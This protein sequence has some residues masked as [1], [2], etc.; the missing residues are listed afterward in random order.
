MLYTIYKI[1]CKTN[2]ELIYVGSTKDYNKRIGMHKHYA[3]NDKKD[4]VLYD[5]I[6]ENGGWDNWECSIIENLETDVRHDATIREGFYIDN[7]KASLNMAKI[8]Y[9]EE[10]RKASLAKATKKWTEK[11]KEELKQKRR[12]KEQTPEEKAR[13][14]AYRNRPEVKERINRL[15]R[16]RRA[17]CGLTRMGTLDEKIKI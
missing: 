10:L 6:K 7:L 1:S 13:L 15:R 16:E 8:H 17:Q 14:A 9:T 12:E 4:F 5:S 3:N 2:A 11:N